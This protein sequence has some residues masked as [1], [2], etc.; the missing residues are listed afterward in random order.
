MCLCSFVIYTVVK[1]NGLEQKAGAIVV[2]RMMSLGRALVPKCGRRIVFSVVVCQGEEWA[3]LYESLTCVFVLEF[4]FLPVRSG[5]I[6]IFL[7]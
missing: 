3:M 1:G 6:N 2:V 4:K 5:M 7:V